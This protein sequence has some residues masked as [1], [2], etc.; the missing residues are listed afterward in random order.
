MKFWRS[1]AL[2]SVLF[3]LMVACGGKSAGI[4]DIP[5]YPGATELKADNN[6]IGNTLA[7]NTEQDAAMRKAMGAG[8]STVQK[9]FA[10]PADATWDGVKAFYEKELKAQGWNTGLGGIAGGIDVN[11]MVSTATQGAANAPQTMI[12]SKGKQTLTMIW[13]PIPVKN[14]KTLIFSLSTR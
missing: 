7:K 2:L 1:L 5:A 10:L 14:E 8:G 6:A 11:S 9:G 4:G 3:I 12:F 13:T